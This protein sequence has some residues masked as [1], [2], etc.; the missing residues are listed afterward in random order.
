MP[1]HYKED[2]PDGCPSKDAVD[3]GDMGVLRLVKGQKVTESDF[4]SYTRLNRPN[5]NGIPQCRWSSCSVFKQGKGESLSDKY[6][7]LPKLKLKY[8]VVLEL[9]NESGKIFEGKN[10]HIDLWMYKE[11][12]PVSSASI[13]VKVQK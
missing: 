2:L 5:L 1:N 10:G 4:Y 9:N 13:P 8:V 11:F 3:P 7:F 12:D 6:R